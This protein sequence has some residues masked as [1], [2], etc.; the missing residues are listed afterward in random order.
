MEFTVFALLYFV[1]ALPLQPPARTVTVVIGV[2]VFAVLL[3]LSFTGF[4]HPI[5]WR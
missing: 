2:V 4:S 5:G 3:I 1:L